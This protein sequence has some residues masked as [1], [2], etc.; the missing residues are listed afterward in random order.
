MSLMSDLTHRLRYYLDDRDSGQELVVAPN[1]GE[2]GSQRG[3]GVN[4]MLA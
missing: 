3:P 1:R 4:R 2:R